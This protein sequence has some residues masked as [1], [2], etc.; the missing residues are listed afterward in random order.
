VTLLSNINRWFTGRGTTAPPDADSQ[1]MWRYR[2]SGETAVLV[3]LMQRLGDDLFH[4]LLTQTDRP[5]AEDLYQ[6]VWL[7]VMERRHQYEPGHATF[8]TWLFT[9]GRHLMIDELRRQGR[10]RSEAIDEVQDAEL[11]TPSLE[12]T[13]EGDDLLHTFN[14]ALDRLPFAQREAFMLQQEG[15]SLAEISEIT[16]VGFE[17]IKS[18]LRFA[19]QTLQHDLEVHHGPASG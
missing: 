4:F 5:L 10:W 14:R 2:Q 9:L 8:K 19:R 18:R 6:G 16:G 12:T 7:R 1:L 13:V 3:Q 15:F 17:T 11:H